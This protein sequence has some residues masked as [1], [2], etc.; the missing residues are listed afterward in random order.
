[1]DT[2]GRGRLAIPTFGSANG[3]RGWSLMRAWVLNQDMDDCIARVERI[4]SGAD[5]LRGNVRAACSAAL[6]DFSKIKQET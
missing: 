2:E 5:D 1:V 6:E 3:E 4:L